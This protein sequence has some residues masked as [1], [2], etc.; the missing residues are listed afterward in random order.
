MRAAT[1]ALRNG[2]AIG[3]NPRLWHE[4]LTSL[5]GGNLVKKINN[6]VPV[7]RWLSKQHLVCTQVHV[8]MQ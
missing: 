5:R 7:A 2:S 3:Y 4:N 8:D 6:V 1:S